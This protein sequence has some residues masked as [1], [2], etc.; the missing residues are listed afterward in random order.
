MCVRLNSSAVCETY[1]HLLCG[2]VY[3][4]A[5]DVEHLLVVERGGPRIPFLMDPMFRRTTTSRSNEQHHLKQSIHTVFFYLILWVYAP[6][7][8]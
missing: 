1:Q 4:Q 7:S 3:Q 5:D 2:A 6:F 8:H